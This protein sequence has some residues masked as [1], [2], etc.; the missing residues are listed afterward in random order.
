VGAP[1]RLA[2][3]QRLEQG[4][5]PGE[6][7]PDLDL[8][9]REAARPREAFARLHQ[10]PRQPLPPQGGIHGQSPQIAARRF[11]LGDQAADRF[12]AVDREESAAAGKLLRDEGG[13]LDE[14]ARLRQQHAA[15]FG[16]GAA[17][18]VEQ[19]GSLARRRGSD[20]DLFGHLWTV[21]EPA[22]DSQPF[23][24]GI[25]S[26]ENSR[27]Y[28]IG[29]TLILLCAT[30][31][32]LITTFSKFAYEAGS[33]PLTVV[34]IRSAA[35]ILVV[36][37]YQR[38]QSRALTIPRRTFI[39]TFPMGLGILMM[40]VGYLSSVYFIKVS[41]AVV[42]LYS[43]PL[44]VGILAAVSGRERIRL[45]KAL[46][47]LVAFAGLVMA[48]GL[49]SGSV[50]WRGVALVLMASLGIAG[51]LTFSGPYLE[52][53][54]SLTVNI[55]NNLWGAAALGLFLALSGG[56]A[57]PQTGF[58]WV[59][60]GAVI[61]CYIL[62]LG[63]MFGALKY[64]PP[65]QAAVMLNLEPVITIIVAVVWRHEML[66]PLQWL[67]VAIMLAALCFSALRGAKSE[68]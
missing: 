56:V 23:R 62:G 34:E 20:D 21:A 6:R 54:N 58:G 8:G 49:E 60:L 29:L 24:R 26:T 36:A 67:G 40:S 12:R 33:N 11:L 39:A 27:R 32:S 15:I 61:L 42:L 37:V 28:A 44:L 43:F 18:D 63:L 64:L 16:E 13:G 47:L 46:A 65:S 53:V 50:D 10:P 5:V 66:L 68:A 4:D 35:F 19:H 41:L 1:R 57:L 25:L 2:I 22:C 7:D 38:L 14:H 59:M 51:N 30:F 9:D 45:P 3:P 31:F 48:V 52:G 55:W 17:H